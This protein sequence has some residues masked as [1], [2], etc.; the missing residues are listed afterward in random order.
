MSH[1]G[2]PPVG[3]LEWERSGG[4]PLSLPQCLGLL[5]GTAAVLLG[6][7]RPRLR[8]ALSRGG[9]TAPCPPRKIDLTRWAPPRTEAVC[10]A[11]E[12]LRAVAS[13]HIIDHSFRTYSRRSATK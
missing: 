6:D 12:H 8:W 1:A 9:I 4:P 3:S 2:R 5:A 11:E 10:A 7:A 13:P